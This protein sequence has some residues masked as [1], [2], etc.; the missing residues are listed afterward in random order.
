MKIQLIYDFFTGRD[1]EDDCCID[2]D[3]GYASDS[4]ISSAH[5]HEH[6]SYGELIHKQMSKYFRHVNRHDD[7]GLVDIPDVIMMQYMLEGVFD[8]DYL[9]YNMYDHRMCISN[10]MFECS[11]Y[12]VHNRWASGTSYGKDNGETHM[13]TFDVSGNSAYSKQ[14]IDRKDYMIVP[15]GDH[16]TNI[17]EIVEPY[18]AYKFA[19]WFA[20]GAEVI[21]GTQKH[22]INRSGYNIDEPS[23]M[24]ENPTKRVFESDETMNQSYWEM[25]YDT[26]YMCMEFWKNDHPLFKSARYFISDLHIEAYKLLDNRI[27]QKNSET[28]E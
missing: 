1:N 6:T 2:E 14:A 28:K 15:D 13:F 27:N 23:P 9:S 4:Y 26:F 19:Q 25:R 8:Y 20:R 12:G 5:K 24:N 18:V 10:D 21:L 22:N 11:R 17:H 16:Y 3:T 7:I